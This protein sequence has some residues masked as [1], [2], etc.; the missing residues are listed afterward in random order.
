MGDAACAPPLGARGADHVAERRARIEERG[1][2]YSAATK[3]LEPNGGP[4]NGSP[5][6][7][8]RLARRRNRT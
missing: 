2:I 7:C 6:S 8:G 4:P 1:R 3:P 5:L